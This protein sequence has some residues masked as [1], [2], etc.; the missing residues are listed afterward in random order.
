MFNN[1]RIDFLPQINQEIY[2]DKIRERKEREGYEANADSEYS[3]SAFCKEV[4][5]VR[6]TRFE[7]FQKIWEL[8]FSRRLEQKAET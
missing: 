2:C 5:S 7:V 3:I 8:R 6:V 4:E 1:I